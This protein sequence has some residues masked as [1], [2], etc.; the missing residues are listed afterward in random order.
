MPENASLNADPPGHVYQRY[1]DGLFKDTSDESVIDTTKSLQEK[2]AID[3]I[4]EASNDVGR[5]NTR[6]KTLERQGEVSKLELQSLRRQ[7]AKESRKVKELSE[8]IVALKKE[9]DILKTECEQLKPSLKGIDQQ[10]ISNSGMETKNVSE[11]SEQIKQELLLEKHLS[12][13]LRF[14]LQKT[15]DSNSELI[16]AVRDLKEVLSRKNKEIAHLSGQIKANQNDETLKLE[17]KI[18]RAHV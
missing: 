15:E 13:K 18:G 4:Q 10:E 6:I 5:L 17:A 2:Y 7:M 9:R 11:L 16:L 12:K 1:S 3:K 14:Q 8:Q